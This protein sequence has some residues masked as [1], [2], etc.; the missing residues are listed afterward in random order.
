MLA[1]EASGERTRPRPAAA[2]RLPERLA[3]KP[4]SARRRTP[5]AGR[6]CSPELSKIVASGAIFGNAL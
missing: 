5:H 1:A 4:C 6:V 3:G 2:G